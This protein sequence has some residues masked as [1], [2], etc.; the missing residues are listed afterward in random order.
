MR[1]NAGKVVRLLESVTSHAGSHGTRYMGLDVQ[2]LADF[3]TAIAKS[4][5]T[6]AVGDENLPLFDLLLWPE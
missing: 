6:T 3:A 4:P 2:A 1:A 5:Q